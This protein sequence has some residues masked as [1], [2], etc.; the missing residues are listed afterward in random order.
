[1]V[2]IKKEVFSLEF[3]IPLLKSAF[4]YCVKPHE[5]SKQSQQPPLLKREQRAGSQ[6][7]SSLTS[8]RPTLVLST[9][10]NPLGIM[11]YNI[12]QVKYNL[13]DNDKGR[14]EDGETQIEQ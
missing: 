9:A 5:D 14:E 10:D 6:T 11:V 7:H 4:V 12:Q 1:M 13:L 2:E 3:W 8:I